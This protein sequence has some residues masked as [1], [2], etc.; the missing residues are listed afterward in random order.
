[1]TAGENERVARLEAKMEA[2]HQD[3]HDM[4]NTLSRVWTTLDELRAMLTG[5]PS[6]AVTAMLTIL[7]SS[8]VGLSVA[9]LS[10]SGP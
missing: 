6:W 4:T 5:R 8:V 3:M 10:R 2:V 7:T 9:L 1:V